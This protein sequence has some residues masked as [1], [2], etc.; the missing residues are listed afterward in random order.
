TYQPEERLVEA[1]IKPGL[2]M[3]K[4]FVSE[5]GLEHLRGTV[6]GF[7]NLTNYITRSSLRRQLQTPGCTL[8]SVAM[9][10]RDPA[11]GQG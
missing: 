9:E 1:S 6:L 4:G 10:A 5:G 11:V 3:R 7:R 2:N 8:F